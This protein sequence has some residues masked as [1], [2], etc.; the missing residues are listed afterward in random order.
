MSET[1]HEIEPPTQEVIDPTILMSAAA[2]AALREGFQTPV[3][4]HGNPRKAGF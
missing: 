4:E 1:V 3:D 2:L